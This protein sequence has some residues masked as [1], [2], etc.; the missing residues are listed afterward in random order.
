M[1]HMKIGSK[2]RLMGIKRNKAN[3]IAWTLMIP[4]LYCIIFVVWLPI[5]KAAY[6]SFFQTNGYEAVSFIGLKNYIHV[7]TDTQFLETFINTAEYVIWSFVIGFF[8]PLLLAVF[9]NEVF[10]FKGTLKTLLYIP[11]LAP[12]VATALIWK[13]VFMPGE[14]GILNMVVDKLGIPLQMWL[15]DPDLVIPLIV[16]TMTWAGTPAT[17]LIYFAALKSIKSDLYEA[18]ML[19]GAGIFTKF[20]VVALPHLAPTMLLMAMKQIIGVFQIMQEPLIMTGGGPNNAS[21]TLNLTIYRMAFQYN[22]T[23]RALA[24]GV[25]M[26]V[27]L[28]IFSVFYFRIDK[29]LSE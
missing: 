16:V 1:S 13:T 25:I 19:D 7:L 24:L 14:S 3:I 23:G 2:E 12:G 22:Q 6:M 21:T 9:L 11:A 20:R 5:L 29:K 26:F 15:N 18:A 28:T 17:T 10:H 27:F 8:V 4:A